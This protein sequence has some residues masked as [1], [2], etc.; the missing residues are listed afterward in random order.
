MVLWYCGR[1]NM[2]EKND[3]RKELPHDFC[4]QHLVT[5]PAPSCLLTTAIS[6]GKWRW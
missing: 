3:E 4:N 6:H 1:A 5:S 2:K